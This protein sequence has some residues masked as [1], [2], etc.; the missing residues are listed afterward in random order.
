DR[1]LDVRPP[2]LP[3]DRLLGD[4]VGDVVADRLAD[5]QAVPR[6]IAGGAIAALGVGGLEGAEDRFDDAAHGRRGRE[7]PTGAAG[8]SFQRLLAAYLST[9]STQL[10]Q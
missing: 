7:G 5:F 8:Q 6:P 9:M 4:D 10:S 2:I 3:D 1:D